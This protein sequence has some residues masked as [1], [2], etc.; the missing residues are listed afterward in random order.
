MHALFED[1][2][3]LK[4]GAIHSETDATAQIETASGRRI[5]VK[6][7]AVLLRFASPAPDE[8]LAKA[9]AQAGEIDLEL[10]WETV[11]DVDLTFTQ[12]AKEYF[13]AQASATEQASAL[14]RLL[15]NP[16]Y[17]RKRGKG[18]FKRAPEAELNAAIAGVERKKLEAMQLQG[19]ADTLLAGQLPAEFG[20]P[21]NA[22]IDRLLY[23][24]DKS[25]AVTK[26]L[27]LACEQGKTNPLSLLLTCGAIPSTHDYHFRRFLFHTFP[28]GTGFPAAETSP[29]PQLPTAAVRGFSIDDEATTEIDDAF[30]VGINAQGETVIGIHIAAPALGIAPGSPIDDI[31]RDRLSTVYM[32][33]NK[34]TMLPDAVVRQFTLAEGKTVPALSLYATLDSDHGVIRTET[35]LEA[36]PIVANLRL[37]QLTDAIVDPM[38]TTRAP[39]QE[40]MIALHKFAKA[41]FT[42]RGKNEINRIDYNFEVMPD[43]AAPHDMERAKVAILPRARGSAIDLIVSELMIFANAS[44]GKQLADAGAAGM[45]RIQGAGKTRM[46]VHPGPHEGLGVP[47]YLWSTSPIRRYSDLLNQRQ[48]IALAN[49]EAL[50]YTKQ[51]T[52]LLAAV[53][54]FD[55][56]YNQ[57]GDFQRQM[58]D[59]WCCRWIAQE[60][61]TELNATVIRENLVRF[62][63][64]PLVRRID[65]L[66]FSAPGVTVR[67]RINSVNFWEATFS[68]GI[69]AP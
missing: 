18:L 63:R 45:F 57:Y 54:D 46:A 61:I 15:Q 67:A 49:G 27:T 43:A 8:L 42:V 62:E 25:A 39:W 65:E 56:T 53:A 36:V 64:I 68:V 33:G 14:V 47:Y 2:G 5:K 58:E 37:Q 69:V 12:I 3:D 44:W 11:P 30:S 13:G 20:T 40:E 52:T 6:L 35:K 9:T 60:G 17:F 19:W 31:A 21:P 38:A 32:P 22:T 23:A 34:I 24:P 66:P 51:N 4:A 1:D 29:A 28:K 50:P 41:R 7:P 55:A 48:L 26:A 59:Y 16:M 10:L